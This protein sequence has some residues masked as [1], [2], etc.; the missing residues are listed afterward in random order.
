MLIGAALAAACLWRALA[1]DPDVPALLRAGGVVLG[2][3]HALAPGTFD[4]PQFRLGDCSTQRLLSDE[5]RAQARRIGEWFKARGPG[6]GA[7]ALQPLVPL[8]GHGHAGLRRGRS[9]G[10][11]WARRAAPTERHQRAGGLAS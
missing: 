9:P 1:A 4:P 10:R 8:P 11:R 3:R 5:G 7:R 6:A 2:I